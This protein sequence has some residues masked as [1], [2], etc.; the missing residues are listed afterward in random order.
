MIDKK[1]KA[2]ME[3]KIT[4]LKAKENLTYFL[5]KEIINHYKPCKSQTA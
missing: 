4:Y 3:Y 5:Y 2:L 1:R